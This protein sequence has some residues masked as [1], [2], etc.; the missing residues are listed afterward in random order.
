LGFG[1]DVLDAAW[2]QV[3]ESALRREF[4]ELV[5]QVNGKLRGRVS[6]PSGAPDEQVRTTALDDPAVARHVNGRTVKKV[7]VVPGKLVNI[8]VAE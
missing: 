5:V 3:D 2:P 7:V 6:V 4:V 1:S 8:V